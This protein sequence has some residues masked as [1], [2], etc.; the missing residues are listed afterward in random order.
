MTRIA[1]TGAGGAAAIGLMRA[2][3]DEPFEIFALDADPVAAG[4][5]LVDEDRRAVAP[6]A[7]EDW[8]ADWMLAWCVE[9]EIDLLGPTVED[10]FGPLSARWPDF[11]TAGIRLLLEAPPTISMCTD[12]WSLAT[13]MGLSVPQARTALVDARFDAADWAL[14]FMAKPRRASGSRGIVCVESQSQIAALPR[15]GSMIA[16]QFL[17]GAE[18][19]VDVL[20]DGPGVV[21]AAVPRERL[22]VDSGIAVAARTVHDDELITVATAAARAA[23]ISFMGNV[24]LRRDANGRARL[25]EINARIPGTVAL[26]VA[27]GVNMPRHI[28]RAALGLP[29]EHVSGAFEEVAMVRMLQDV[30]VPADAFV[31]P[32]RDA[33]SPM[34]CTA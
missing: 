32:A 24:Q 3:A 33:G 20:C 8:F 7:R 22:K 10:E 21:L 30:V 2:I 6:L 12:K 23:G 13:G 19:S 11:A 14:P 18:Y 29:N 15:D 5:F 28:V 17:P 25:L 9:H 27:A 16:Q 34:E 1:I 31:E 4:L 26:T